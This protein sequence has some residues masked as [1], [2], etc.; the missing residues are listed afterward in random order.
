ML[1]K[2]RA[3]AAALLFA[4]SA[5]AQEPAA[6][7]PLPEPTPA[8]AAPAQPRLA[9]P[10][11]AYKAEGGSTVQLSLYLVLLL[12]LLAG[13]AYLLRNGFSIF[14][15][16]LKGERKLQIS[17]TRMLGNRQFLIVAEYEGRKMLLGVCPGRIDHLCT[18]GGVEPEFPNIS[19]EKDDA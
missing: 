1:A 17:E 9:T 14:Q 5:F 4:S 13:G 16:K 2:L 7:T 3:L 18:L 11:P 10:P 6:A 15:P 12:G 8:S 19:P